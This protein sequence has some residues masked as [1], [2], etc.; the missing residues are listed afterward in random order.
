MLRSILAAML[1]L[2]AF[3][4]LHAQRPVQ[5]ASRASVTFMK[6]RKR[7][8]DQRWQAELRQRAPWQD[9]LAA[10]PRWRVEFNEWNHKPHRAYGPPIAT[11]GATSVER[12]TNFLQH[13]LAEMDVPL[14]ELEFREPYVTAKHTYVHFGQRHEGRE[15]LFAHGM[16]KLDQQGRVICFGLDV[17]NMGQANASPIVE[18]T[19]AIAAASAGLSDVL[20]TDASAGLAWLPVP[21]FRSMEHHLVHQVEVRTGGHGTPGRWH[22]LVDATDGRLLYRHNE[23]MTEDLS[24][25]DA[26]ADVTITGT[27]SMN[28]LQ[29][30]SEQAM[31]NLAITLGA[32]DF[33]TDANGFAASGLAGPV[34]YN[35]PLSGD[36]SIVA[37]AGTTPSLTGSLL[38]G[39]NAVSFDGDATLQE[40]SAYFHVN[41]I[42]DHMKDVLP[43]FTGMDLPLPTNVDLFTD[44]C[45]AFYDGS[46]INFYAEANNCYSLAII[47]D[48]PYHEYGHG[49]NHTFY[50]A[51]GN[52]YNNGGMDEGYADVW[53]LSLTLEPVLAAGY[54]ISNT[55]S[56]IRRYDENKK[57]YPVDITG[58]VHADGEI[59]AGAWWDTYLQLGNDMEHTMQLFAEA[60]PGVQAVAPDGQEGQAFRD[61][62][63]D[64]LQADDDDGNLINGTPNGAAISEAFRIHGITLLAGFDIAHTPVAAVATSTPITLTATATVDALFDQ[65]VQGVQVKYRVNTG[66]WQSMMMTNT[67][68][69][70]YEAQLPEQPVGTVIAYY[71]GL[72]DISNVLSSETPTGAAQPDPNLPNYILVGYDLERTEDV[73][74]QN[75]LGNWQLGMPGDNNSTG[76][77]ELFDPNPTFSTVDG[78]IIQTDLQHTP[79]GEYCF[80]TGNGFDSS[81]P[82]ENDVDGGKTTLQSFPIDLSGYENPTFT[83]WRWYTNSPPGGA[84]PGQDWWYVQVT[85]NGND[86]VFVENTRT[87]ERDWRRLAFRVQD[88]V[89]PTSTFAIRFIASDSTHLGQNLDGGS[90]VE[91][92]VDDIQLWDNSAVGIEEQNAASSMSVYP[93]PAADHVNVTFRSGSKGTMGMRILDAA[94]R[95]VRATMKMPAAEI[96]RSRIDVSDLAPGGYIMDLRWESGAVRRPFTIVR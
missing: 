39:A 6:D 5:E 8:P 22:C 65:Y 93:D 83:L 92:A 66:P 96:L 42:H 41:N 82:G 89:T 81:T 9:F 4:A 58:E 24:G 64:V 56:F 13:Q 54:Q 26:G 72:L 15:V 52:S 78:S 86:W 55:T 32:Q 48:V 57:V 79:G 77:W 69:D 3:S 2:V 14:A 88:Y 10:H 84:N 43:T 45:N 29:P 18:E 95:E 46:S 44:N 30:T 50:A 34:N 60:Y 80:F 38:E 63:I 68:G 85:A 75:E 70:N 40:R 87:D 27:V 37:T 61:V 94:G 17:E 53:A 74:S 25:N 31:R 90:L 36:W 67:G 62:L 20:S 28:P 73:D 1:P 51:T 7:T 16:V 76:T 11:S 47:A 12:A 21:A 23:V 35:A 71:I 91:A 19:A 49:I 59:I 33:T